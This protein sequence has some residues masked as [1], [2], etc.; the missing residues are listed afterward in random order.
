MREHL[1]RHRQLLVFL[2]VG[3]SS[4]LLDV[5]VMKL[6]LL[7][8]SGVMAAT[9][10]G[11]LCGF[12]FNFV[13]HARFTFAARMTPVRFARYV[14]V[15]AAN[16]VLTVGIVQLAET[17]FHSPVAGKVLAL[18]LLP[19]MSYQAGKHWIYK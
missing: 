15:V 16:Y 6:L 3:G 12:L 5:S 2:V 4:A 7:G 18:V 11:F 10:A 9:T 8:G 14:G 17:L 1:A 19:V 13:F